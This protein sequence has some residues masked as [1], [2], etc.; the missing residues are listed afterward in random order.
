MNGN[1]SLL[2]MILLPLVGSIPVFALG[3]LGEKTKNKSFFL[4]EHITFSLLQISTLVLAVVLGISALSTESFTLVIP[5]ICG[6]GM[7]FTYDGFRVLY[8]IVS[9]LAWTVSS[10]FSRWYMSGEHHV[11]RYDFFTLLTMGATIGVFLSADL[12]TTFLFF[13]IMSL[14]SFVWV[15]Q[16]ETKDALRA[17]ETYLCVAVMGGLVMLM[18]I[19]L[20][21]H[22]L[23]TLMISELP[24]A[25]DAC[26]NRTLLHAAGFCLLF[27]F[28]AKAG[29]FPLHIW[30]PKAHPVAPAPAS[31]LLSGILTKSGI[32]GCIILCGR[33]FR[34][35]EFWGKT[36]LVLAVCTMLVG[37]LIALFSIDMK[38][39]LACSS[40]SQIGFILTG[41][42]LMSLLSEEQGLAFWG[43][44]LHMVNHSL[45]KLI[46]FILAGIC[47]KNLA[48]RDLNVLSG[49]GRNKPWFLVAFLL[50]ALGI[51]GVPGFSGYVS[52][53]MLHEAIVECYN[54][55]GDSF[56]KAAEIL[57]LIAGG[58]TLAYML[59]LFVC[60]FLKEPSKEVREADEKSGKNYLP[61]SLKLVLMVVAL[62]IFVMGTLPEWTMYRLAGTA[63]S[64][65]AFDALEN[66][67]NVFT[68]ECLKGGLISISIGLVLYFAFVQFVVK[69]KDGE[70]TVYVNRW[71]AWM[72]LE[73]SLYRPV[74]FGLLHFLQLI[75]GFVDKL[76][77]MIVLALR[78][79]LLRPVC[80]KT[81]FSLIGSIL[82]GIGHIRN[83]WQRLA[84][85][86]YRKL[87]PKHA[88]Y[89]AETNRE[90]GILT[91]TFNLA[92]RSLSY[93]LM[94]F[95]IGLI[96]VMIYLLYQL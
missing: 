17:A 83:G 7:H 56:Y 91:E 35:D 15:A 22:E 9:S 74:L 81:T 24:A 10:L 52:K 36:M 1:A 4:A 31:A 37:A 95:C 62:S 73:N 18:G 63:E 47:V 25:C 8:V 60:L 86:T 80:E 30:L 45:F 96:A 59:K 46:L 40:V 44:V 49:F 68:W 87:R 2:F 84:N 5:K 6:K 50:G 14:A 53:T 43:T 69:K 72:D 54:A 13:E 57:F 51:A 76:T 89:V 21:E 16:E 39:V 78:K 64:F 90:W 71:P 67:L 55:S 12:Y 92:S 32:F 41:C 19:F 82:N 42:A 79:T 33:M 94:A 88:D 27:G 77:E 65:A 23:G 93:G 26:K 34:N 48:S 28:G 85:A 3:K 58:C 29:C 70:Q 11:P 66:P 38:Q 61:L 75:L 20:L